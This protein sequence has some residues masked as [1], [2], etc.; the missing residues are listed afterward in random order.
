[1]KKTGPD[2]Y[3]VLGIRRDASLAALKQAYRDLVRRY[4]PDAAGNT[5]EARAQFE[6]LQEAYEIL[7]NPDKRAKYDATLPPR[8]YPA[9]E[10]DAE[11]LWRE[12]TDLLFE[13]SDSF[14]SLLQTMRLAVP[15]ALEGNMLIVGVAGK[16]QYLAGH[17]SIPG[18]R[19]RVIEALREV[20]GQDIDYRV[21]EGT[22]QQ[23][24]EFMQRAEGRRPEPTPEPEATTRA[25]RPAAG[26]ETRAKQATRA[27][28]APQVTAWELLSRK[29]TNG[30]GGT[31]NRQHPLTRAEFLQTAIHWI[32]DTMKDATE[33]GMAAD[34]VRREVG[35]AIERVAQLVDI[36]PTV[37]AMELARAHPR[38]R[39]G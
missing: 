39:S 32:A 2:Y 12:A 38:R 18:N 3:E 19:Y 29:I 26:A 37:V 14:S 27:A 15:I 36:P 33:E 7:S 21:I 35:K 11:G 8:K 30:W 9:Q 1:M 5:A 23:D 34:A 17:L 20:S 25:A 28:E 4:H 16:D 22:T 24:W 6:R 13:R 31:P 10:L